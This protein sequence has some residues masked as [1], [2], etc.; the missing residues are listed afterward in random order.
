MRFL[1]TPHLVAEGYN[2]PMRASTQFVGVLVVMAAVFAL[3]LV[4]MDSTIRALSAALVIALGGGT[5]AYLRASRST[6]LEH[7]TP[8]DSSE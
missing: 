4:P 8:S 5:M 6:R 3:N 7:R 1:S 2:R